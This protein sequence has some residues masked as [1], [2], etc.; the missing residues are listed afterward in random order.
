MI[1][2]SNGNQ[3][4]RTTLGFP[5]YMN[6]MLKPNAR[7]DFDREENV[8]VNCVSNGFK[9][10]LHVCVAETVSEFCTHLAERMQCLPSELLLICKGR[11][12]SRCPASTL[13]SFGLCPG[14]TYKIFASRRPFRPVWL[15]LTAHIL[16]CSLPPITL[17][18]HATSPTINI[19]RQLRELLRIPCLGLSLHFADG[20]ALP[21]DASLRDLGMRDGA[22][23]YCRIHSTHPPPAE[24]VEAGRVL[25]MIVRADGAAEGSR[26][27][28]GSKRLRESE[29]EE[30]HCTSEGAAAGSSGGG[31]RG[32]GSGY[33]GMR[34]GFL[35]RRA[36]Q[37]VGGGADLA[38]AVDGAGEEEDE[39][40]VAA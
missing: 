33:L 6:E 3:E 18:M 34:R 14:G 7:K 11:I 10:S 5:N 1:G 24:A 4:S 35:S 16:S 27:G 2:R 25:E 19:K 17:R 29:D 36:A 37:A 26:K 40:F 31:G 28:A 22:R 9:C 15:R 39:A 38:Q 32:G 20:E 30:L 8:R 12:I 13:A 23:I 21:D